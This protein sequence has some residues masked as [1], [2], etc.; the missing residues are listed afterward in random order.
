MA[1]SVRLKHPLEKGK[2]RALVDHYIIEH[3]AE[4]V[5]LDGSRRVFKSLPYLLEYYCRNGCVRCA[6]EC[7]RWMRRCR[8]AD[9]SCSAR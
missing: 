6:C 2:R 5:H 1:L 9:T 8:V 3:T 4:G 7:R